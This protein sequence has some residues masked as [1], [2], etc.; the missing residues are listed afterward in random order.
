MNFGLRNHKR[1]FHMLK[2]FKQ[3]YEMMATEH[4]GISAKFVSARWRWSQIIMDNHIYETY[5]SYSKLN[6]AITNGCTKVEFL[7]KTKRP[8]YEGIRRHTKILKI[9]FGEFPLT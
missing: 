7:P 6:F 8:F 1:E 5:L 3:L 9:N 4:R 2:I